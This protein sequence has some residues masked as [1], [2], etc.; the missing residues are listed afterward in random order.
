M[1]R[2]ISS[3]RPMTGS[4]SPRARRLREIAPVL[5]ES[6]V[7][8]LRVLRGDAMAA[9]HLLH[10]GEQLLALDPQS[11]DERKQ[12]VL[13]GEVLVME[14]GPFGV[15]GIDHLLE[16]PGQPGLAPIGLRQLGHGVVGCVADGE[17]C[18]PHALEDRED[19]ALLLAEQ[20]GKQVVGGDLGVARGLGR[21]DGR[22]HR[23]LG[24]LGPAIGVERHW[25]NGTFPLRKVDT[26]WLKSAYGRRSA[27]RSAIAAR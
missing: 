10:R 3:S 9:A 14:V 18:Q 23:L 21:L 1:T 15:R 27:T 11:V 17:G 16:L 2:R 6:L 26:F 4:M 20:R 13:G 22:T 8:L 24:L 25:N 7:L 12:E 19:D 5:L